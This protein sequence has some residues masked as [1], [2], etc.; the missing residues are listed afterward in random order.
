ME[1]NAVADRVHLR[2]MPWVR[3]VA[4]DADPKTLEGRRT[5]SRVLLGWELLQGAGVSCGAGA[6]ATA[7]HKTRGE[8]LS[9]LG[10]EK[11]VLLVAELG[12][13]AAVA[14]AQAVVEVLGDGLRRV[15][16]LGILPVGAD[17]DARKA[18]AK[19][20][21]GMRGMLEAAELFP[22]PVAPRDPGLTLREFNG[23]VEA[24]L[25]EAADRAAAMATGEGE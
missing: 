3:C 20:L 15:R 2:G 12:S 13:E 17:E 22:L 25:E 7:V 19:A 10:G 14:A 16:L 21:G 24:A 23:L 8:I 11:E 6:V 9:S 1:G 4:L 18:A 5:P